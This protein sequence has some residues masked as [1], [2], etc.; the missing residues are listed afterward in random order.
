[1]RVLSKPGLAIVVAVGV[2]LP[3]PSAWGATT[4]FFAAPGIGAMGAA[5]FL[6]AAAPL[7]DGRVLVAGGSN[8]ALL[9]SAELFNPATDTFSSTG[10]GTMAVAREGAASAPLPDGRVLIA[11]GG[12]G[13]YLTSAETFNPATGQFLTS[14]IGSLGIARYAAAAAPLP[15]GRGLVAAGFNNAGYLSSAEVF[16]PATG[17]F[18]SAGIGALNA[19]R[20][21]ATAAPLSDGRVLVVGGFNGGGALSSAEVFNPATGQ[22]STAGIG[23]MSIPRGEASAVRLP[24][25]RVLV[26]GGG[27]ALAST[28]A[29]AEVFDPATGQFST[30]GLGAMSVRRVGAAVVALP[31]GRVLVAGGNSQD[32]PG[33][34]SSAEVF[35]GAPEAG[36]A[37]G[38]FG[39]QTVGRRTGR[40]HLVVTSIAAQALQISSVSL[41]GANPGDFTIVADRCSGQRLAFR[42]TCTIEVDF[43]P[44]SSGARS[45]TVSLGDN[46][47]VATV[48]PL[49][50]TGVPQDSGPSGAQ[51]PAGVRGPA[52]P[53]GKI[54]LVTC[55]S[56][57]IKGR[58]RRVCT[59][60][61]ITGTRTFTTARARA[62]LL[63]GHVIYATGSVDHDGVVLHA[64][65]TLA[66]GR[67]TLRLARRAHGRWIV[68]RQGVTIG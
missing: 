57:R 39:D 51:G 2:A 37:G 43:T 40:Q 7:P 52:G 47:P 11:G 38:V 22:F 13:G 28:L 19:A 4:S 25:G 60:K 48:I 44:A 34:Q 18:S 49:T 3:A 31:D 41:G 66:R 50:G 46:E 35:E 62:S 29:S 1:M 56:K 10:L 58:K 26:V 21:Y 59:T 53:A 63:R 14:G 23:S 67:Y 6:P 5:R 64:S 17:Q 16:N 55:V 36:V 32:S 54:R 27:N 20:A 42:Q 65:R 30:A 9:S 45:A 8:A 15:D 68:S 61:V 24:N 33:L 12:N